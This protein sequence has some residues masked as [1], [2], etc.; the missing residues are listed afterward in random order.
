MAISGIKTAKGRISFRILA[1]S[2][3]EKSSIKRKYTRFRHMIQDYYNVKSVNGYGGHT[4]IIAERFDIDVVWADNYF[5]IIVHADDY[6]LK[7]E[8]ADKVR[9]FFESSSQKSKSQ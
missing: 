5:H 2:N 3:L 6:N 8:I 1:S 7:V 4:E 9:D